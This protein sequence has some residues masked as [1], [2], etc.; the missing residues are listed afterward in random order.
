M[1]LLLGAVVALLLGGAAGSDPLTDGF[2]DPPHEYSILPFWSWNSTLEPEKLVWQM[3][4]MSEKG[5]Y[6]AFMH[7][8]AGLDA[9]KTPYFSEGFWDA[10]RASVEH[11]GKIGFRAWM[12][13]E[14][15]W[16]SGAAG[17]RTIAANPERFTAMGLTLARTV[18]WRGGSRQ[19]VQ[20]PKEAMVVA[21][22]RTTSGAIDE[23]TLTDL[24]DLNRAGGD[25][26]APEGDWSVFV[27]EV[28]RNRRGLPNY[29]N[30]DAA[31]EFIRNTY[32]EY[33]KRFSPQFGKTIPGSFFDEIYNATPPWDPILEERF[34]KNKGYELR[35]YLP[36]L[37]VEGGPRTIKVRCDFYEEYTKLYEE[38]W[39]QQLSS[40]CERH[41]LIFT[42]HTIE[43]IGEIPGQGD[44][45]RIWRHPQ[46][47]G[48]DNE[49]FRYTW[50]RVIGAWK[51]K[52]LSSV[53]HVYGRQRA[54]VE[55][56]GGAGWTLTLDQARYGVNM[57]SAYGVNAYVLHLFHYSMD[58]RDSM[59][60]WPNSWFYQNPYWKYFKKFADLGRRLSFMGSQGQHVSD[61]AV[62]YPVEEVWSRGFPLRPPLPPAD[63]LVERLAGEQLDCDVVDTDSLIAAKPETGGRARVGNESYKVLILPGV[64]T[65]SLAAYRRIAQLA[66]S[67]LQVMALG[68]TPRHSAENGA[69]D[70]EVLRISEKLFGGA[71]RAV[72][73]LNGLV[74]G[75]RKQ[76]TPDITVESPDRSAIRYYHRR[77]R[78][79]DVYFLANGERKPGSARI[80]FSAHGGAEQWNPETGEITA[81]SAA[82]QAG[83]STTLD[84]TF[85]PWQAYYVVFDPSAALAA[86]LAKKQT[87]TVTELSGPWTMQLAQHELDYVW[88]AD[89]GETRV[90]V[91]VADFRVERG[92]ASPWRRIK[93]VDSE[94]PGKGAA[95]YVS[96]WDAPW[97]TR[98]VY[99]THHPGQ[100]AGP[101]LTFR[102]TFDVGFE[103]AS[104]WAEVLS[105]GDVECTWNGQPLGASGSMKP[106]SVIKLD[107]RRGANTVTCEVKRT[108][109]LL[110]QGEIHGATG[111][112]LP[113]R[114]SGEWEVGG[115]GESPMP[116]YELAWPPAGSWGD[117]PLRGQHQG[118][119]VTVSYRVTVPPG[120]RELE[121]PAIQGRWRLIADGKP[122]NAA[123]VS[124]VRSLIVEVGLTKPE[125]GLQ[126]PLVFRCGPAPASLGDWQAVGLDWYSGRGVY[127]T[128]FQRPAAPSG[129][130][131]ALDLG[132]LCYTGEVWLNGELVDSLVW[133]PYRVDV[134]K[135]LRPGRNELT[136]VAANLLAN[137]MR[138]NLFDSAVSVPLSRW[139]HDGNILRD[140]D[141]LRSGLIGPVRLIAVQ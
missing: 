16:P 111:Q 137:E 77:V 31:A 47:P 85:N 140:G 20:F 118:F 19:P 93:I 87:E 58:T 36:L 128:S 18:E 63:S 126:R 86:F 79:R 42:G 37:F 3:D 101:D 67:G 28:V 100:L 95:R 62:L 23:A 74:A 11:A 127:R 9:S 56:L 76:L 90:E 55:A 136:V 43:D 92:E 141:K 25:W 33:A 26:K 2:R 70:P 4:Q 24:S 57:L 97:I 109:F 114:T 138:W 10:V 48:T 94:N 98:Y 120:A 52:Q 32:E 73:D 17:G 82:A 45:F 119:P 49:D 135:F 78:N 21:A 124:G 54:M 50:P 129:S 1:L 39:F 125:E 122:L 15:Q 27:F 75:L 72:P 71:A 113:L 64:N 99:R 102:R 53:T 66:A 41:G 59:D 8:R 29:I 61:V 116:A 89:P 30:P 80:R 104:G 115:P 121:A 14:D 13:D 105:D 6:G 38:A 88:K 132:E 83:Q 46:M 133:P 60:D 131:F 117:P 34:R 139:W 12:Y 130:T 106:L 81:L 84:L 107:A 96:M 5:L 68:S 123:T 91:P 69:D 44:Y 51:P 112:I 103:P 7:S 22:R 110:A 65:V 134:T 108:G 35:K 40:W